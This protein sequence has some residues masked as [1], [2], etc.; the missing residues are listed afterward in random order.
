MQGRV[1]QDSKAITHTIGHLWVPSRRNDCDRIPHVIFVETADND[2][3]DEFDH[4]A[5]QGY[6]YD[7]LSLMASLIPGYQD[8][9]LN[10]Y[11]AS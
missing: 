5:S 4:R 2:P 7:M 11:W 9:L 3:A 10:H 1:R 6:S 8:E